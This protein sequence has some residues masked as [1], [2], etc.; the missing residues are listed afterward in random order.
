MEP[1]T[2]TA[3]PPPPKNKKSKLLE[4]GNRLVLTRGE[5]RWREREMVKEINFMVKDEN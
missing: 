4:A 2:N 3:P 5:E 1:E